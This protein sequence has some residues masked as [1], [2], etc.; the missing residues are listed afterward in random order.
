MR[1]RRMPYEGHRFI[2]DKRFMVVHDL[3]A[4]AREVCGCSIDFIPL[5]DV[6]IFEPDELWEARRKGFEPCPLCGL[7]T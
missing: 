1:R 6:E 5:S 4:E 7:N 2:G 3:D